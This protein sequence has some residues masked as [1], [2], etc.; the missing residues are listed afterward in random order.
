MPRLGAER[1]SDTDFRGALRHR[2]RRDGIEADTGQYDGQRRKHG[3]HRAVHARGPALL[4]QELVHGGDIPQRQV[5]VEC[6]YF[7]TQLRRELPGIG[8]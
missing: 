4:R 1:Q 6:E 5:R 7:L 2:V 8:A 3:E